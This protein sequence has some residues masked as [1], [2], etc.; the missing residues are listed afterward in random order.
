M[1][2][3]NYESLSRKMTETFACVKSVCL[4]VHLSLEELDE[5]LRE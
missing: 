5:G 1:S 3:E 2:P 4:T